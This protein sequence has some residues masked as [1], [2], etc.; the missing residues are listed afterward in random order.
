M[1]FL[2]E[3]CMIAGDREKDE[4]KERQRRVAGVIPRLMIERDGDGRAAQKNRQPPSRVAI[5]RLFRA[6][7]GPVEPADRPVQ[8]LKAMGFA[9]AMRLIRKHRT[10]LLIR[11]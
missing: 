2:L 10:N 3:S 8:G 7:P 4:E 1:G 6:G 9:D 5:A 11:R